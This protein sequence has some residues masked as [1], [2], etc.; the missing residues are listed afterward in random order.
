G[1]A[2]LGPAGGSGVGVAVGA[3]GSVV[4]TTSSG[5]LVRSTDSG[6]VATDRR[7][8]AAPMMNA[9]MMATRQAAPMTPTTARSIE[10]SGPGNRLRPIRIGLP[11]TAAA[12]LTAPATISRALTMR[13]TRMDTQ[14]P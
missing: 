8:W 11:I 10:L 9:G 13:R 1:G 14:P 3:G 5:G 12:M 2:V 4:V 7:S 6:A